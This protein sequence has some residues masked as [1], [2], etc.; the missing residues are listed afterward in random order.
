M[1]HSKK[2]QNQKVLP[3]LFGRTIKELK[4]SVL[5]AFSFYSRIPVS[6][7]FGRETPPHV[8][9]A[10]PLVGFVIGLI[11]GLLLMMLSFSHK[12][13]L[14]A[15]FFLLGEFVLTGGI[16]LDG[17]ADAA[18]AI[19]SRRGREE[20]LRIMKDPHAGPMAII[21]VILL[22]L[23]E[24]AALAE[25]LKHSLPLFP[26][27]S[28]WR[29]A[30]VLASFLAAG[31]C[32]SGYLS[33]SLPYAR[34]SGMLGLVKNPGDERKKIILLLQ[35]LFF[36]LVASLVASIPGLIA[37]GAI[38]PLAFLSATYFRRH[39]GG[40]TGDL[41]GFFLCVAEAVE[42]SLYALFLA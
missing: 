40:I 20:E 3:G 26:G 38:L 41:A 1:V 18:D 7:N 37:V 14:L 39:Y 11:L 31:R 2:D 16:H 42:L 28:G 8:L 32:A 13:F 4:N 33:L 5:A 24:F 10:F 35:G 30:L 36:A 27:S 25:I 29:L 21:S 19:Y 9:L 6:Q 22:L 17:F 23:C 34:S 12:P 15:A